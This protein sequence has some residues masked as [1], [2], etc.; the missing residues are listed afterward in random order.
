[1]FGYR[2]RSLFT[3]LVAASV[4]VGLTASPGL[5]ARAQSRFARE[6]PFAR[7]RAEPAAPAETPAPAERPQLRVERPEVRALPAVVPQGR[8]ERPAPAER[9]PAWSLPQRGTPVSERPDTPAYRPPFAP[10]ERGWE[11]RPAD[12]PGAYEL[13]RP[14]QRPEPAERGA[15]SWPVEPRVRTAPEPS[16]RQDPPRALAGRPVSPAEPAQDRSRTWERDRLR[17]G[18]RER[19]QLRPPAA[20][21][22][23]GR[24]IEVPRANFRG[25]SADQQITAIP[26]IERE[27]TPNQLRELVRERNLERSRF[28]ERERPDRDVVGNPIP[29]GA[30]FLVR[31]NISRISVSYTRVRAQF[32]APSYHY[33]FIPRSR[34]AYWAGYWDGYTD[35]YWAAQHYARRP[36]VALTFYYGFYYSDPYWFGFWYP[37]YYP[38]IYHYWGWMPPWI[39]PARVYYAPVAYVYVP[40][41]PYRYYAG[42]SVDEVGARRAIEDIRRSWFNAEVEP[43]ARHLTDRLDIRVYFD[44]EYTYTTSTEDYYAMTVD[45]MATT[46]T[47]AMDFDQPIWLSSHEFFVTGRHVF[48]DPDGERQSVYVSYRLRRL[49]GEWYIVAVGSSLEPIRHRYR[50]FRYT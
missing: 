38:A 34:A 17:A 3:G 33:A 7:E 44:G 9:G 41:T 37:G 27:R 22:A 16:L 48:Y 29:S 23:D 31:D 5:A 14:P 36:M 50:D 26:R 45:A 18:E 28:I 43:L 32:G 2:A 35:G 47:V 15:P 4:L 21:P 20:P 8:L 46:H 40:V 39:Y 30:A 13:Y 24:R 49:S 12:R 42:Q 1:M 25:P 19:E 6:S 11:R 10:A